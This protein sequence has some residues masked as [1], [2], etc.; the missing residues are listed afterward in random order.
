MLS[1]KTKIHSKKIKSFAELKELYKNKPTSAINLIVRL[2]PEYP[3][4]NKLIDWIF[5]IHYAKKISTGSL[6]SRL[7]KVSTKCFYL[8]VINN[9]F[10][11][12]DPLTNF[13]TNDNII[14]E[15]AQKIIQNLHDISPPITGVF[16]DYLIRRIICEIQMQNF[17]DNRSACHEDIKHD[18][19]KDNC[20]F[21]FYPMFCTTDSDEMIFD[22]CSC[23]PFCRILCGKKVCDT[24]NFATETILPEIFIVSLSHCEMFG[25]C[26]KQETFNNL[27]STIKKINPEVFVKSLKTMC[28]QYIIKE[29]EKSEILLN[30]TLGYNRIPADCDIVSGSMLHDLKCSKKSKSL[31]YEMLQLLGYSALLIC[32]PKYSILVKNVAIVNMIQNKQTVYPVNFSKDQ[33]AKYLQL[34]ATNDM[35]QK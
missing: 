8:Y 32:N 16:I 2:K 9:C 24:I 26:P 30:P 34:L 29:Y 7:R 14:S 1:N 17:V 4:K 11:G 35:Q 18:C 6:T 12:V 20:T 25:G 27:L 31:Y 21:E 23:N 19:V 3:E 5:K 33:Y 15:Y 10:N 13:Q 22:Y 28:Q